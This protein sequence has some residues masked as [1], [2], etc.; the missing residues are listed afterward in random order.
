[1]GLSVSR[2]NPVVKTPSESKGLEALRARTGADGPGE[3]IG[4]P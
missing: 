2:L 4:D 3:K 1:M